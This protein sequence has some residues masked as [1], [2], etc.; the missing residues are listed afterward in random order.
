LGGGLVVGLMAVVS[1]VSFAAL[2][3]TGP[4]AP[5]IGQGLGLA[6]LATAVNIL[7]VAALASVPGTVGGS[8]SLPVAIVA[9]ATAGIA[10]QLAGRADGHAAALA[11]TVL[12]AMVICT[13]ATGAVLLLLGHCRAGRLV[14]L[15]PYPVIGG[16]VAA[17]GWL[18]GQ[19]ALNMAIG[20]AAAWHAV[21]AI[22]WALV[23]L[24]VC[25]RR[26]EPLRMLGMMVLGVLL[27]YAAAR[28]LGVSP[29]ELAQQGWLLQNPDGTVPA[30]APVIPELGAIDWAALGGAAGSLATVPL[31]TA[32]A[33]MLNVAG[34]ESTVRRPLD[35][36][37]ELR[38]AGLANMASGLGG[39]FVGYQQLGLSAMNL[40]D[41]ASTRWVGLWAA[42]V[43]L[44]A[45][46]F[47]TGLLAWLPRPV[48]GA[49]LLLLA[50]LVVRPWLLQTR[51]RL[52]AVDLAIIATIVAATALYGFLPAVLLGLAAAV[53]LFA[54]QYGRV[55]PVRQVLSGADYGSRRQR[56]RAERQHLREHGDAIC[57]LQL[58]GYLFFGMADRVQAAAQQRLDD[59]LRTAL[60][61]VV[62][63]C[64]RVSGCDSSAAH[65]LL[66]LQDLLQARGCGL[67]VCQA[68]A[69]VARRLAAAGL[70]D[71]CPR[72]DDLDH[73]LEWCETALLPRDATSSTPSLHAHLARAP[74][75]A[76]AA[77]TLLSA[78]ERVALQPGE[79]LIAQGSASCG[80]YLLETGSLSARRRRTGA[81]PL[82]LQTVAGGGEVLGEVGFFLHEP[83]TAD[84]VADTP[85]VVWRLTAPALQRLEREQPA[86]A[87]AVLR[88][89]AECLSARVSHLVSVVDALE[90]RWADPCQPEPSRSTR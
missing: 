14:R 27:F 21:P 89:L 17:T 22:G 64:R 76:E 84:V 38:A 40:R 52:G 24:A 77:A 11:A 6:L 4:L 35:V 3:Y 88:L 7:V 19:G 86:L 34:L 44:A 81:A 33:L 78:M 9:A 72:F 68:S 60:R 51:E 15:L 87:A 57:V 73:G 46:A 18:L 13:L 50:L 32:I 29:A 79:V 5:Q 70:D 43:C 55:D 36:D 26:A 10:Q 39:G 42:I 62:L 30:A 63:D 82:R 20:A 74:G 85:C 54:V 8:Q 1:A 56:S 67:V 31:V 41:G 48:L 37:R 69:A 47:G 23:M 66:R 58:Q 83:R 65:G 49:Q 2:V 28:L 25:L 71:A 12:A 59:A 53:L 80:L 61:F 16:V 90:D 45:L 75:G